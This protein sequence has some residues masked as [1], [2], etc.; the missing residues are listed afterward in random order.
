MLWESRV[1]CW[2]GVLGRWVRIS[3]LCQPCSWSL[4]LGRPTWRL[5]DD[6]AR[7]ASDGLH[8]VQ[9]LPRQSR[10]TGR[11]AVAATHQIRLP[12]RITLKFTAPAWVL[13][14]VYL[15]MSH[16]NYISSLFLTMSTHFCHLKY[17]MYTP[18]ETK[19]AT[20]LT[21]KPTHMPSSSHLKGPSSSH[22]A[23]GTPTM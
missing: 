12:A 23:S 20:E 6:S 5:S 9:L 8:A 19:V 17:L 21:A 15:D 14:R 4:T 1:Q 3:A 10:M 16:G 2:W 13:S 11:R 7:G 22:M 18:S